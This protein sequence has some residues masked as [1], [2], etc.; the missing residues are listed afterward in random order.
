MTPELLQRG[1]LLE[2]VLITAF[3]WEEP[4]APPLLIAVQARRSDFIFFSTPHSN[5]NPLILPRIL[6]IFF[7]VSMKY[8]P[9]SLHTSISAPVSAIYFLCY[10]SCGNIHVNEQYL[11]QYPQNIRW[12]RH[13]RKYCIVSYGCRHQ[14]RN[15]PYTLFNICTIFA[16][17]LLNTWDKYHICY[18]I[19]RQLIVFLFLSSPLF[20][21]P[22]I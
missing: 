14:Y 6:P 8:L 3:L 20:L 13:R 11:L 15:C 1:F 19:C 7:S 16:D 2:G 5:K 18:N 4:I 12:C 10:I 21:R 17:R 9:L 22:T